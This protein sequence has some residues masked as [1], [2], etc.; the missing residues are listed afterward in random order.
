M[1][2]NVVRVRKERAAGG[3][4]PIPSPASRSII[5]QPGAS[6]TRARS[7][8]WPGRSSRSRT[9]IRC[10]T[11]SRRCRQKN[12]PFNISQP[13]RRDEDHAHASPRRKTT[14]P[15]ECNVHG[16]MHA[17]HRR[18]AASV[19]RGQRR[20]WVASR[21]RDCRRARTRS[22]RGTRSSAH[23]TM[24]VT[25]TADGA[26]ATADFTFAATGDLRRARSCTWLLPHGASTFAGEIDWLYYL[27]LMDHRDRLRAGGGGLVWFMIRVPAA[28]GPK[29]RRTLTA[30]HSSRSS[31][32]P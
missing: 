8:S 28:P 24:T 16:W 23:K 14:I 26:T 15:V 30:T 27:I 25:V 21:S 6:I 11:T 17:Q 4:R 19:L 13:T 29:G 5:D 20:G 7:G 22:K 9:A 10:C 1:L 31:G 3:R 12:R 18:A 32:R 2:A